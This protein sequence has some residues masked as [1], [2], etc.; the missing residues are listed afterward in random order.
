MV[1]EGYGLRSVMNIPGVDGKFTKSNHIMEVEKILGIEAARR[2]II[3]EILYILANHS[4]IVDYRHIAVLADIM[5]YRGTILG[6]TRFGISK[7]K[8]STLTL[9][10]FEKTTDILYDA[11][12]ASKK[13]KMNGVSEAIILVF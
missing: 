9:A 2:T 6:I 10:S 8:D 4:M 1:V 5:T 3:D 11:A 12:L 7:M 13:D